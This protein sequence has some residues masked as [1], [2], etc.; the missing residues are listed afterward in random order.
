[1]KQHISVEDLQQLSDK[2]KGRL[3]EWWASHQFST[4]EI[5]R[6]SKNSARY[7]LL[8]IGQL[9]EFLEEKDNFWYQSFWMINNEEDLFVQK[10]YVSEL[11]DSLWEAVKE[12]LES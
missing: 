3:I 4:C 9:I 8:S 2:G 7:P 10:G 1:M 12:V 5:Y 11:C 6:E